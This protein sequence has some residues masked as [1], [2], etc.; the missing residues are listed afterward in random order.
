MRELRPITILV[1]A[2][3]CPG[4]STLLRYL[5]NITERSIRLVGVDASRES[6][7]RFFVSMFQQVPLANDPS[8]IEVLLAFA[9]EQNVDCILIPSSYEVEVISAKREQFEAHGIKVLVSSPEA[10]KKANNKRLLYELFR[11][12][13]LVKVPQFRVVATLDDFVKGCQEMGYPEQKL[14][15]KPPFSKGS[16][17]FRYLASGISRADLL[18]NYKP[19]SKII[20]LDEMVDIFSKEERFPE[21]LLM[22]TAQ[23]EEIDSMVLAFEGDPLII[24]HKTREQERGGVITLG[25]HCQRPEIDHIIQ[26]ILAKIP[27]SYNV[28]IQF[29]GGVLME[30]NPRLS[31][32]LYTDTWNEPYFAVKMALGEY[33]P[34]QVRMLREKVPA[35][36]RMIRYFD[37][38]F[39]TL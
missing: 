6:F 12:D 15:F 5:A 36:L 8:Y 18:L 22:E 38:H 37:Q 31:T 10:L 33:T 11:E 39:F 25:G 27:L 32:F 7:G 14:C 30:I 1:T 16:R 3:G 4:A 13:P 24:T 23:G 21:L 28:G 34:E 35:N 26:A 9:V 29:K 2:V 17:G 20:T 19:D